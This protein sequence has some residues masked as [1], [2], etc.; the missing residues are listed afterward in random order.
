MKK[1]LIRLLK[2]VLGVGSVL[3]LALAILGWLTRPSDPDAF[4][5]QS[6]ALPGLP[7]K[8]LKTE[9]FTRQ[10]PDNARGWR[11]L[12]TTTRIDGKVAPASAIVL[13]P[14]VSSGLPSDV[15]AW[16]HGTTG[17]APGCA[18]S[19][20]AEPFANVPALREAIA[21]GW[22]IVATDYIGLGTP[23]PHPYLIGEGQARSALDS[24]RALREMKE[25]SVSDKTVVW[26]HS[27]GGHAAMWTG[28]VASAYAPEQAIYGVAAAA[29]ATDLMALFKRGE[30]D[31]VGRI[32]SSYIVTAYSGIYPDVSF[33]E[34]VRPG[35][36]FLA[37]DIAKRC[38]AGPKAL[39][40]VGESLLLGGSI[41]A[42]D[43]V[44]GN[45][46]KRMIENTPTPPMAAPLFIAQGETDE[47]VHTEIQNGF[48]E[49]LCKEGRDLAY[50]TYPGRDHLTLVAGD[51]PLV[52]DLVNWTKERFEGKPLAEGCVRGQR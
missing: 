13:A 14:K 3:V 26:G 44:A 2:I 50:T 27:Q 12:Y 15:V 8:L 25:V 28:I 6:E 51:S 1:W 4:Y 10:V 19:L 35:A 43:A 23:G 22:V 36:R 42:M 39:F 24:L 18:P 20:L 48:V 16:T 45:L 9:P 11:I 40:A 46:G 30:K 7:G 52:G 47:L 33:D 34:Y 32:L 21:E 38:M 31:V 49:G 29:P 17:V 37:G 41:F 5:T